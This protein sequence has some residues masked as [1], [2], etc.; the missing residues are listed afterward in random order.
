VRSRWMYPVIACA[1][2]LIVMGAGV[3]QLTV[4]AQA[5]NTYY[6]PLIFKP[7]RVWF[8][9]FADNDPAWP[10]VLM[11]E[12][13]D[14]S[15]EHL[16]GYLAGHITDNSGFFVGSPGWKS[17]GPFAVSVDGRHTGPLNEAGDPPKTANGL[18]LAFGANDDWSDFYALIL[19][20]GGAQHFYAIV[21]YQGKNATIVSN[22]GR[23]RGGDMTVMHPWAQTNRL[24]V[25]FRDGV[26]KAYCNGK[27]LAGGMVSGIHLAGNNVGLIVTSYEFD[28]GEVEFDNYELEQSDVPQY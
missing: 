10:M 6:F 25:T 11:D 13:Q 8:D 28:E 18:G 9:D 17:Y 22:N 2:L 23:Y 27:E 20:S 4:R 26:I 14:G 1:L 12:P 16:N 5:G 24:S 3:P 21:H 7:Q 15:F 19:S